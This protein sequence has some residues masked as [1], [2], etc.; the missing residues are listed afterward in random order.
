MKLRVAILVALV[1]AYIAALRLTG[2]AQGGLGAQGQGS[3]P[4]D[5]TQD[6]AMKITEPFTLASVGDVIIVRPASTSADPGLLAPR[7]R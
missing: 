3:R 4:R 1:A 6:M 5:W 7:R 2:V